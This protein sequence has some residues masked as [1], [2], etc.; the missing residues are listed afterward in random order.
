VQ[1]GDRGFLAAVLP[2]GKRAITIPISEVAALSGLVLPGDRVDLILTYSVDAEAA[3]IR[4]SETVLTNIRVLALDQRLGPVQPSEEDKKSPVAETATLEV[5]PE[6][7]EMLTL[8]QTLGSLSLVLNSVRDGGD[9]AVTPVASVG[10]RAS[11][12]SAAE[13]PRPRRRMTIDSDVTSTTKVQVVRGVRARA[14]ATPDAA[15]APAPAT[16]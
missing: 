11:F 10:P 4:A 6:Q 15:P 13:A 8:A 3:A 16:E 12:R 5:T 2:K 9:D 14:S 7:A 1:P